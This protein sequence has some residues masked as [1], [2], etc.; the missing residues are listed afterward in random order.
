VTNLDDDVNS[1]PGKPKFMS[2]N[3]EESSYL[4]MNVN[5]E[6]IEK[7]KIIKKVTFYDD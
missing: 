5:P 2:H 7:K 4:P 6:I 1:T 3:R